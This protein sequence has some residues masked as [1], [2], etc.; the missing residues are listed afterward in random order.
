MSDGIGLGL[1]RSFSI[2]FAGSFAYKA[3]GS[4][5]FYIFLCIGTSY[6]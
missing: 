4:V 6:T 1:H 5:T 3:F 2:Y